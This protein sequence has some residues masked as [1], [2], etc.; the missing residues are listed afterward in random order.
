MAG[1]NMVDSYVLCK[2]LY[3]GKLHKQED[4]DYW[5]DKFINGCMKKIAHKEY[6]VEFEDGSKK[7]YTEYDMV[8]CTDGVS[9]PIKEAIDGGYEIDGN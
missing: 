6:E 3:K 2:N 9:R 5:H 7:T 1:M 4:I 8:K